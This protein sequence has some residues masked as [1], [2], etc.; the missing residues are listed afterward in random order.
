MQP[1][2]RVL[3]LTALNSIKNTPLLVHFIS[4]GQV[5]GVK[6][7]CVLSYNNT[8]RKYD[9][10]MRVNDGEEE[11]NFGR[12]GTTLSSFMAEGTGDVYQLIEIINPVNRMHNVIYGNRT[13]QRNRSV[14][15]PRRTN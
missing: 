2:P 12:N 1:D 11:Q 7:D 4:Y 6:L 8:S 10:I 3:L 14:Q 5:D 15:R 9:F 13:R